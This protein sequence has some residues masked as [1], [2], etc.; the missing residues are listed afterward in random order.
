MYGRYNTRRQYLLYFVVYPSH[1]RP[2]RF[3]TVHS[4]HLLDE[5]VN[6]LRTPSNPLRG[7]HTFSLSVCSHLDICIVAAGVRCAVLLDTRRAPR[8]SPPLAD[9]LH[10]LP[11]E[12]HDDHHQQHEK[13]AGG[14]DST[15]YDVACL[16]LLVLEGS[17]FLV[18]RALLLRR[19]G[20]FFSTE[21]IA[22][23]SSSGV[24]GGA[25]EKDAAGT[26]AAA[27]GPSS[28]RTNRPA[29]PA[30]SSGSGSPGAQRRR[31]GRRTFALVDV[32][33]PLALPCERSDVLV[34][35]LGAALR[36]AFG[37]VV[38]DGA[39]QPP[40]RGAPSDTHRGSTAAELAAMG[41]RA[42]RRSDDGELCLATHGE[43]EAARWLRDWG[44][45]EL[46]LDFEGLGETL[47]DVGLCGLA[48]W[49]LEYP[50]IYCC[51]SRPD[52]DTDRAGGLG[53]ATT[54]HVMGNCLA[55]VP[56]TV[57]SL[58]V[59]LGDEKGSGSS[60]LLPPSEMPSGA[61]GKSLR[62]A[63]S[64]SV[65]E[66]VCGP[67]DAEEGKEGINIGLQGLVDGLL[68]RLEA[69]IARHRISSNSGGGFSSCGRREQLVYGV[70]VSKRTETLDRVAL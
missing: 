57:Y 70:N 59:E 15:S 30:S 2:R 47:G 25:I 23:M 31:H 26:A 65:P 48:G 17:L 67:A 35:R 56:L 1:T 18:N 62:Q 16:G 44:T 9:V 64:F 32:R 6:T 39:D 45:K 63:F 40:P 49:L 55:G 22:E 29:P 61:A 36:S 10:A 8:G 50:V 4:P 14:G 33:K 68:G 7:P 3:L 27:V 19:L 51:P 43:E 20:D 28:G 13:G 12:K 37:G 52:E 5:S 24:A 38:A 11:Q 54:E 46:V 53:G 69:R 60:C 21:S 58:S 66:R 41:N 42:D 34:P